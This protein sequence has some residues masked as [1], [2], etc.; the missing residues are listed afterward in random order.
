MLKKSSTE[1]M[2]ASASNLLFLRNRSGINH[3]FVLVAKDGF[4]ETTITA[5]IVA[6]TLTI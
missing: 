3:A 1:L 2:A 5:I 6:T 4:H